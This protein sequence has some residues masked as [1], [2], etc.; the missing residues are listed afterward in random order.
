M[1]STR[2]QE[3]SR[4]LAGATDLFGRLA[5]SDPASKYTALANGVVQDLASPDIISV[6]EIQDNDGATDSR[7]TRVELRAGIDFEVKKT[8]ST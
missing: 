6:E 3:P 5:P 2:P 8:R 7:I 4:R 1:S